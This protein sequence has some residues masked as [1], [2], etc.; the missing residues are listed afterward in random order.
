[1]YLDNRIQLEVFNN[2]HV[3][4]SYCLECSVCWSSEVD[5]CGF[6]VFISCL[7]VRTVFHRRTSCQ[8]RS[9]PNDW[10]FSSRGWTYR[11]PLRA[12]A[13]SNARHSRFAS[14]TTASVS[15]PC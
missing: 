9:L 11:L 4:K 5:E 14:A 15:I 3:G 6:V 12:D 7:S 2:R 1:M 13:P 10:I 8:S